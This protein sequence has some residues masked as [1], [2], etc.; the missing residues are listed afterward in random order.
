MQDLLA[1]ELPEESADYRYTLYDEEPL[2]LDKLAFGDPRRYEIESHQ[3][4]VVK[5][6]DENYTLELNFL[7]EAMSGSSPLYSIPGPEGPLQVMSGA[8][9]REQRDQADFGLSWRRGDFQHTGSAGFSNENDYQA[10]YGGYEGKMESADALR[11]WSWAVSYSDDEI[12]PSDAM[13]YGRVQ[14]ARREGLSLAGGITQVINR[15]AVMQSGFSITRQSGFLAD[16]YKQVWIDRAVVNDSRPD[17]RILVAW[18]TR[19]RQYLEQS[20]AA[21]HFDVRLFHD[22]WDVNSL[23]L[24]AT[25]KQPVGQG[26]EIAPSV[27]YY[28]QEAPGF[29]APYFFDRPADGLW[30]SDYRLA[31]YGTLSYRISGTFRADRWQT[32]LAA[33]YYDSDESLALFGSPE[34]TPALVDFWRLTIGF[35]FR[36]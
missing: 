6:L 22:D 28:S 23:T 35:T 21:L 5:N 30:S 19:F 26:W 25:W 11:T 2:P 20:R 31:T 27:R 36:L 14:S 7:H 32:S 34:G 4:R 1:A 12:K 16:P 24:E 9:I 33:E 17:K 15:N 10:I 18:T 8:T 29:Y 3:F 13:L